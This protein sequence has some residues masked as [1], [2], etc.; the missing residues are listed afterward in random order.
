MPAGGFTGATVFT[1]GL[2][3]IAAIIASAWAWVIVPLVTKVERTVEIPLEAPIVG[4]AVATET[5]PS[6]IAVAR[7]IEAIFVLNILLL[8]CDQFFRINLGG[9]ALD[10]LT[11]R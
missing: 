3:L 10:A 7:T 4:A 1:F 11:S 9:R 6:D 8:R 5:V 2:A